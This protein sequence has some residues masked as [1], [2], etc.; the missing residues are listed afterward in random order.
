M[1]NAFLYL[2]SKAWPGSARGVSV[3]IFAAG[4]SMVSRWEETG[5]E[6]LRFLLKFLWIGVCWV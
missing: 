5:E 6:F 4:G 2:A 3:V 1:L